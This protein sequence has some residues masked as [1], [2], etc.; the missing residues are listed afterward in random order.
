MLLSL[1]LGL[2]IGAAL[3]LTA[4]QGLFNLLIEGMFGG[5]EHLFQGTSRIDLV[6]DPLVTGLAMPLLLGTVAALAT[7]WA[8]RRPRTA[9]VRSLTTE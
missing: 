2:G 7:L 8:C 5:M 4:G 9:A 6:I 3:S 1:L